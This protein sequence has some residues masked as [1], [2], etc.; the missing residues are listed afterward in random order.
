MKKSLITFFCGILTVGAGFAQETSSPAATQTPQAQSN[1]PT[2]PA[3]APTR[4]AAGSVIPVSLA[5]T[6]DAKKAKTGDEVVAKVMEDLKTNSGA[7]LVPKDT[8]VV[9]HVTE[10]QARSKDQKESQLGITFDKALPK[11]AAEMAMPMSIQAVI[12]PQN[13]Q[14]NAGGGNNDTAQAGAGPNASASPG[15]RA[16]MATPPSNPNQNAS[17]GGT[18]D[19]QANANKRPP[20]TGDTKGVIGIA[21]LKLDPTASNA[22]QGSVMTSEKNNVK[23]ESGT[24]LLLRVNQ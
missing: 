24:M 19:S 3:G 22:S 4:I 15:G 21:N 18:N 7:V 8:K 13:E 9:G 1:A 12:G 23:L 20:I 2:P 6:I 17:P 11:N 16:G 10:V 14:N 5:K